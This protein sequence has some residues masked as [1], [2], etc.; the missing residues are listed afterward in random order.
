MS[1]LI[2][3]SSKG[4]IPVEYD[5]SE[6]VLSGHIPRLLAAALHPPDGGENE[7]HRKFLFEEA[8]RR[9]K[10]ALQLASEEGKIHILNYDR[11]AHEFPHGDALLNGLVAFDEFVAYARQYGIEV[12]LSEPA[13]PEEE[14]LPEITEDAL[15]TIR[16]CAEAIAREEG[17]HEGARGS[18]Q[19]QLLTHAQTGELIVRHPHTDL[20]WPPDGRTVRDFYDRVMVA[21]LNNYLATQGVAYRLGVERTQANAKRAGRP[22]EDWKRNLA[23]SILNAMKA[24]EKIPEESKVPWSSNAVL[25]VLQKVECA[26]TG[27]NR[28]FSVLSGTVRDWLTGE[29]SQGSRKRFPR[30]KIPAVVGKF[31][32][33]D[34]SGPQ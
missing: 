13:Q 11:T 21:D 32:G 6:F 3:K 8:E 28:L 26:H 2:L 29:F 18:L 23:R 27:K 15:L 4:S 31:E 5:D 16:Q 30:E 12:T 9:H 33:N 7:G 19:K 14:P 10:T 25:E 22:R 17:W 1:W 20:A 24:V 34:F